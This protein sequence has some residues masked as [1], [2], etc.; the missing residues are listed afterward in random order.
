MPKCNIK[1][2]QLIFYGII[3]FIVLYMF[4]IYFKEFKPV[5]IKNEL[6]LT[7]KEKEEF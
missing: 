4:W 2:V 7:K 5:P 3:Q 6:N 1:I